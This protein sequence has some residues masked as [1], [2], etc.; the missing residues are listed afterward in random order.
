M[1]TLKK[2]TDFIN[3]NLRHRPIMRYYAFDW[4]D[5]ILMMP[6]K[7]RMEHLVDGEWIPEQVSTEKFAIVRNDKENWRVEKDKKGNITAYLEFRDFG[8]RGKNAFMEDMKTA[9]DN[10][11]FGPSWKKFLQ[12]LINGN[13]FAIIT[14]RGHEPEVIREGV[15]YIID[16]FLTEEEQNEMA[17]NL[18]GFR[19]LFDEEDILENISFEHLVEDYLD[20]CDFI[21]VTSDSFAKKQGGGDPGSP[22]KLKIAALNDFI[23]KIEY[24]GEEVGGEVRLG[25]SDDDPKNVEN[26]EKHF[27]EIS[28]LYKEIIFNVINTN[29]PN[30]EGGVKKRI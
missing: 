16:E 9:L 2:Y 11:K 15:E 20:Y 7:I 8:P 6:T 12:C 19:H 27:G 22:E 13:I 21:G 4:D 26:V 29:D 25:F 18:M 24:Y 3:E 17:A 28:P 5:N 10:G 14:A 1:K 23:E 30:I